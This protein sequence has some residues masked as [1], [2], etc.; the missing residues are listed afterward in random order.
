MDR[1][2]ALEILPA[3]VDNEA[4]S[5]EE[6]AFFDFIE[7]DDSVKKEYEEALRVKQLLKTKYERTKAPEHL[8][9]R[10]NKIISALDEESADKEK[11]VYSLSSSTPSNK[12]SPHSSKGKVKIGSILRYVAAAAVILFITLVTIQL[13][14]STAS[15]EDRFEGFVVENIA[16]EHFLKSSGQL[17]EPH[18]GTHSVSEAEVYLQDHF[19]MAITVPQISGA[20]FEGIVMADFIDGFQTPL[21]EYT[22]PEIGETIYLFAFDMDKVLG[23]EEL[24]RHQD[25]VAACNTDHDFYVAEIDEHH[26]VSW[27]WNNTWYSAISNH[28]G[29]DLASLV[30]PLQYNR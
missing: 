2:K 23:S 29:Y 17:I 26:V 5:E 18:F 27:L 30:E 1:K 11:N 7:I 24:V 12:V 3:I 21:L 15:Y 9:H 20:Q 19:G 28:N 10:I 8:V 14:D 25:A 22:Q 6:I 16:A 4:S 13:L